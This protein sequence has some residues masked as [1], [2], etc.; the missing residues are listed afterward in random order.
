M[1]S[2]QYKFVAQL[3]NDANQFAS[4]APRLQRGLGN[5][6][7]GVVDQLSTSPL[8]FIYQLLQNADDK[9]YEPGVVPNSIQQ[10]FRIR[11]VNGS[12][13]PSRNDSVPQHLRTVNSIQYSKRSVPHH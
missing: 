9:E 1:E 6:V 13:I 4:V 12:R 2:Q 7:S 5:V 8:D 11:T 3:A 10:Q